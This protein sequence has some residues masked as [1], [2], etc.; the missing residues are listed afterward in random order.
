MQTRNVGACCHPPAYVHAA[1]P[2]SGNAPSSSFRAYWAF[3]GSRR[4]LRWRPALGPNT[5]RRPEA[6]PGSRCPARLS[7]DVIAMCKL[8]NQP[9][10]RVQP[11]LPTWP[12]P[13]PAAC[14]PPLRHRLQHCTHP[15][16]SFVMKLRGEGMWRSAVCAGEV[17]PVAGPQHPVA[18]RAG[19]IPAAASG[20]PDLRHAGAAPVKPLHH[21]SRNG[22]AVM[23]KHDWELPRSFAPWKWLCHTPHLLPVFL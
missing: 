20:S 6:V 16:R 13:P 14:R 3:A 23:R 1:A 12:P 15:L 22:T 2:R 9:G 7:A 4:P 8:F 17:L 11:P 10:R 19:H 21:C 18:A 5:R